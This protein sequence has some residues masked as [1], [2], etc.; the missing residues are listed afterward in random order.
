MLED[1][2]SLFI[3]CLDHYFTK[4]SDEKVVIESPY[5]TESIV[6]KLL[7]YTGAIG[8]SGKYT[9]NILF[10][11][12]NIFVDKLMSTHGQ[13]SEEE[14]LRQ[15][16]IGE[17][18]NT[19]SGNSRKFLGSQ[20]VISVPKMIDSEEITDIDLMNEEHAYVIPIK[21]HDNDAAMIISI[22]KA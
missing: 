16:L 13:S 8:I 14:S 7:N 2:I 20:F 5:L 1:E 12:S 11:A 15:D 9:G 19:L 18:V 6:E 4:R 10:T 21:W 22:S 3:D 17:V